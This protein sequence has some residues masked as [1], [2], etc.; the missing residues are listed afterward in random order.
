[1][2][3]I[4]F[5]LIISAVIILSCLDAT[6]GKKEN[7]PKSSAK[8]LDKKI[9]D[10]TLKKLSSFKNPFVTV[11]STINI[12]AGSSSNKYNYL[13]A[14]NKVLINLGP[15]LMVFG[16]A[17]SLISAYAPQKEASEITEIKEKFSNVMNSISRVETRIGE[18]ES[19]MVL[20][21]TKLSF[22]EYQR[23]IQNLYE[24]WLHTVN[25]DSQMEQQ[26]N[27][28]F[29]VKQ[30]EMH[31]K[32][33]ASNLWKAMTGHFDGEL[34][35][36]LLST[37]KNRYKCELIKIR[38]LCI[39]VTETINQGLAI[40]GAY[41][42]FAQLQERAQKEETSWKQK[43]LELS[44]ACDAVLN[45]CQTNWKAYAV[46]IINDVFQQH[47]ASENSVIASKTHQIL[48]SIFQQRSWFVFVH[49]ETTDK[50]K[51]AYVVEGANKKIDV[52]S[53]WKGNGKIMTVISFEKEEF[54]DFESFEEL[55][56]RMDM[57]Q[58]NV[59][60]CKS[61][62]KPDTSIP[63]S[64]EILKALQTSEFPKS[65]VY[66]AINDDLKVSFRGERRRYVH[67]LLSDPPTCQRK[68]RYSFQLFLLG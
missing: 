18:L 23:T 51:L 19:L 52:L 45:E 12:L 5:T 59:V 42:G 28:V 36:D 40:E 57:F 30:F 56:E 55:I 15:S 67:T 46:P 13:N 2:K 62:K 31:Y 20:E 63:A 65:R 54:P 50:E 38:K 7:T 39:S 22:G 60:K 48:S 34:N 27:Q 9:Q 61:L 11:A 24:D 44:N 64:V 21:T 4:H 32:H 47:M 58:T 1:M 8:G 66:Y 26:R 3:L 41:Y 29:F 25:S 68:G 16:M 10:E 53:Q 14:F 33:A 17:L 6:E 35:N 37:A 43:F 49:S